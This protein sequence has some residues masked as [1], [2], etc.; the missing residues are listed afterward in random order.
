MA[1]TVTITKTSEGYFSTAKGIA[2]VAHRDIRRGAGPFAAA[3][4]ATTIMIRMGHLC[5]EKVVLTAPPE[6][7]EI[8]PKYFHIVRP[9]F[10]FP[11]GNVK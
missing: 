3:M 9:G 1:Q 5:T 6:V 4:A 10:K 2:E 11:Q 7:M 8:V